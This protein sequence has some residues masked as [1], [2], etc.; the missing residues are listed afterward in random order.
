MGQESAEGGGD[1]HLTRTGSELGRLNC[2]NVCSDGDLSRRLWFA[3]PTMI[4]FCSSDHNSLCVRLEVLTSHNSAPTSIPIDHH[5]AK[6]GVSG[7]VS[8]WSP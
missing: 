4:W 1:R 2:L 7:K 6:S 8:V 5:N 3:F